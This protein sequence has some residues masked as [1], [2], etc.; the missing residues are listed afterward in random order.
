MKKNSS[1]QISEKFIIN[2]L[3]KKLHFNKLGSFKFEND[4]AYLNISKNYKTVVTTDTIIENIDFFKNDP[5][6]SVAQKL[7]CA[8]LSDLSAMGSLPKAYTLNLSIPSNI[9]ISWLKKFTN[10]LL[11]LQKKYNI[12]LLGG[13]I[14]KSKE[15]NLTATFFGEAK[16]K[17]I[18]SQNKCSVGDDI[19]VTGDLG[20]SYLGYKILKNSNLKILSAVDLND[21]AKKIIEA[22]K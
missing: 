12:Y 19:W 1:E 21:A 9:D 14:S 20:S 22:I 4:A 18:L 8:N 7:M 15:L 13:D 5:P 2:K 3:L 16:L 11:L 6:E 10:R 17:Y